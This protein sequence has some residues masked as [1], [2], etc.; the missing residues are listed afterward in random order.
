MLL[1]LR[2]GGDKGAQTVFPGSTHE[3]GEAITWDENEEPAPAN[4]DELRR[5]VRALAACTLIARHWSAPGARHDAARVLGGFLSR[6]GKTAIEIRYLAEAIAKAAGDPEWH[7]R[8]AAAGDAATA[9]HAGKRAYGL[10]AMG[11][12][13]GAEVAKK[14]A[15]WLDYQGGGEQ[16]MQ[17]ADE[18]R[19]PPPLKWLDMSTWDNV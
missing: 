6:A 16:P 17:V 12:M 18:V 19:Q 9:H 10:N 1:E 13:F 4:A 3:S 11:N 8:R 7:D 5:R 14:T 15:E 2:I